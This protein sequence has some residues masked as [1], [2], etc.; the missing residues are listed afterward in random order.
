LVIGG[1][2]PLGA[3][4]SAGMATS[5]V[6]FHEGMW[7]AAASVGVASVISASTLAVCSTRRQSPAEEVTKPYVEE[8]AYDVVSARG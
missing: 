8:D 5:A 7:L 4:I 2:V 3:F 1:A 6:G